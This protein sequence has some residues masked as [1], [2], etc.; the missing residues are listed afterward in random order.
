MFKV[1]LFSLPFFVQSTVAAAQTTSLQDSSEAMLAKYINASAVCAK[2]TDPSALYERGMMLLEDQTEESF[3]AAADCFTSAA[4]RNHTDAQIEL[5]KLYESGKGVPFSNIFAY[6]WFQTAVLLGNE[7][8]VPYRN[9][10]ESSMNL[11]EISMAN[12]LIQDTLSLIETYDAR[13]QKEIE[14]Y[15]EDVGE[16]YRDFGVDLQ[17][18][19]DKPE[20]KKEETS[21]NLLIDA[22]IRD[23]HRREAAAK[24]AAAKKALDEA[25]A[26]EKK[27][28][29]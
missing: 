14:Q 21:G 26:A 5:G 9:K 18:F 24:K 4:M 13:Q 12:P 1:F 27:Q 3:T 22:L 6:K 8:A 28:T 15:E 19:Q 29:D 11:D 7:K 10:I 23:E 16:K 17:Q 2:M 20:E 25:K